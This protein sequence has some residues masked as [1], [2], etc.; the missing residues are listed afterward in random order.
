MVSPGAS[1]LAGRTSACQ[2]EPSSRLIRVA[3]IFGSVDRPMRR[4][5]SCAAITLVSLTTSWSPGAS[6]VGSSET[7]WSRSPPSA[8]TTSMRAASRG[9][10]G[11]SAMRSGGSSKSNRSVRIGQPV[12]ARAGG[13]P[14]TTDLAYGGTLC[15]PDARPEPVIGEAL[16]ADPL[17]GH[18]IEVLLSC[19]LSRISRNVRLDDLVGILHRLAALDLDDVV[20]AVRHLAP[21]RALAVEKRGIVKAD[22]E[23]TVG[24]VRTV[25]AGHR[26]GAAHMGL[27]VEL[28]LEFL[29][30]AAGAGAMGTAGLGHESLDHPMKYDP[31]V[32]ALSHELLD[33]RDMIGREVRPHLDGD[34]AL[35]GLEN[36]SVFGDSHARFSMG[37]GGGLRFLN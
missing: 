20:H 8:S 25:G 9:L 24:R 16:C 28:G 34:G 36:Q 32:E 17:A 31:V 26:R 10:A 15:V 22:E 14:V 30:G 35:R 37:S 5:Q 19:R 21:D 13:D 12:I 11:R 23:L 2:R 29:A 3:S 18:H 33:P 27:L 7:M 1:F 6:H 4:P